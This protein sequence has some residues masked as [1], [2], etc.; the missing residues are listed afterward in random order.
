MANLSGVFCP[1]WQKGVVSFVHP[2]KKCLVSFDPGFFCLAP[3]AREQLYLSKRE[4]ND[5][6]AKK[7][8]M[9]VKEDKNCFW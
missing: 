3:E 6:I 5:T 7:R 1:Q 8:K 4:A 2:G 9:S